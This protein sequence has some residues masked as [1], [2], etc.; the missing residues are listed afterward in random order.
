M[1]RLLSAAFYA[2]A[3]W[4]MEPFPETIPALLER[5]RTELLFESDRWSAADLL[6][7]ARAVALGLAERLRPYTTGSLAGGLLNGQTSI[8]LDGRLVVFGLADLPQALWPLAMHLLAGYVWTAVRRRPDRQRLLVVD[9]AWLLLQHAASG[10]FLEG[11]ARLARYAGLGL[12]T[13]TQDV[14]D[15]LLSARGQAIADNAAAVLL[16][17][18]SEATIG[19]VTETF[20]LSPGEQA[21][22]R[23][24]GG[25]ADGLH[26]LDGT[27]AGA[28]RRGEGLLLAA[29]R[30]IKLKVE[31]TP[32]EHA[33]ATTAFREVT[34]RR[35][36]P[37]GPGARA[38]AA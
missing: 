23:A 1:R 18:Q 3:L 7:A 14:K 20:N 12:V 30:R 10:A 11:M 38:D 28:D 25:E 34:G 16:L 29:G 21:D 24:I 4:A 33:L 13:I 8:R 32:G 2:V 6:A 35:A 5:G 36:T 17:G 22:L 15:V 37:G 31:A 27:L 9:E 19:K 26:S